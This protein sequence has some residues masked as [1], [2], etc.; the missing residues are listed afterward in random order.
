MFAD[1][2]TKIGAVCAKYPNA[3]EMANNMTEMD[4]AVFLA[5]TSKGRYLLKYIESDVNAS[6]VIIQDFMRLYRHCYHVWDNFG[7]F[8]ENYLEVTEE[9]TVPFVSDM[10]DRR[11]YTY[12]STSEA[13]KAIL[14]AW[15]A[16]M[17]EMRAGML[18]KLRTGKSA[19]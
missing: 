12:V 18:R 9:H 10:P 14:S 19:R 11:R 3:Q 16:E 1:T 7:Q 6:L 5:E 2:S 13:Y 17:W 4:I 15:Y 8:I